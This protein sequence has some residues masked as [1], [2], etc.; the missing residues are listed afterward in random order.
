MSPNK[1]DC[2][3]FKRI[4]FAIATLSVLF[5]LVSGGLASAFEYIEPLGHGYTY[6]EW[7]ISG[8]NFDTNWVKDYG[9]NN[10]YIV[11][12][13]VQKSYQDIQ[14][15]CKDGKYY[16]IN[17]PDSIVTGPLTLTE[18]RKE[19]YLRGIPWRARYNEKIPEYCPLN[20]LCQ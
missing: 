4:I 15:P 19:C 9:V 14:W 10:R 3:T 13:E 2:M 8:P 20:F 17:K 11:I 18:F 12:M 5:I 7:R 1:C 6:L 16:I